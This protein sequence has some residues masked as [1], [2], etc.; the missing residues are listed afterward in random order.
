MSGLAS[1][2]RAALATGSS[3]AEQLARALFV[4]CQAAGGGTGDAVA[5]GIEQVHGDFQVEGAIGVVMAGSGSSGMS[6]WW[7]P[8]SPRTKVDRARIRPKMP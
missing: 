4:G 1:I 3:T 5:G 6:P 8:A 7:W 2:A